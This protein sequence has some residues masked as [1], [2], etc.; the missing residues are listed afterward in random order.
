METQQKLLNKKYLE[1]RISELKDIQTKEITFTIEESDRVFSNSLYVNFWR[2]GLGVDHF[3]IS[4]LRISD[5]KLEE[6]PFI[7]FIIYPDNPLTKKKKAEL[8]RMVE[9][10]IRWGKTKYVTK[11]IKKLT[12]ERE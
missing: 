6:C 4:T 11:T 2:Q 12:N 10:T 7:Q 5:H 8:I 9:E 1:T 3:K